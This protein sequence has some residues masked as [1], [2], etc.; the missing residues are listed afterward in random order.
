MAAPP[1]GLELLPW[2]PAPL[3]RIHVGLAMPS[4]MTACASSPSNTRFVGSVW[5]IDIISRF[6]SVSQRELS[7]VRTAVCAASRRAS[8]P[9]RFA[10][11]EAFWLLRR[12]IALLQ[13]V[14]VKP[15]RGSPHEWTDATR[16]VSYELP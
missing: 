7:S 8:A 15:V 5:L 6:S 2:T 1:E 12:D 14:P 11:R 16:R 10:L 9:V 3:R 4:V 13:D